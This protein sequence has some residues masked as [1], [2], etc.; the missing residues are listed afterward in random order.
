M[1]IRGTTPTVTFKIHSS[2]DLNDI[3][4][5]WITFQKKIGATTKEKT[6]TLDDVSI[7]A[8]EQTVT[9]VL[10]QEDTLDFAEKAIS[11]QMRVRMNDD[12]AYASGILE[13][14]I[15]KILKDGV[16]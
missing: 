8:E 3:A 10:T 13:T 4:E 11:V 16:I 1:I 14:T 2:L 7:D 9:L 5:M 6:F 15:G 12:M